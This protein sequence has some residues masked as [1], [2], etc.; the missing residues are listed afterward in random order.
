M[1][2][3]K[4]IKGPVKQQRLEDIYNEIKQDFMKSQIRET[5]KQGKK[6]PLAGHSDFESD[7]DSLKG[8]TSDEE[9][10]EVQEQYHKAEENKIQ[11]CLISFFG[12]IEGNGN[13]EPPDSKSIKNLKTKHITAKQGERKNV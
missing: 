13:C 9:D 3:G 10:P 5:A 12:K 11:N 1:K 2:T 7:L 6:G 4:P 8:C